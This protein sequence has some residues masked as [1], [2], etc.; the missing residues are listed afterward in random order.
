MT[1]EAEPSTTEGSAR[2]FLVEDACGAGELY[3]IHPF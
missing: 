3:A 1:K 2:L